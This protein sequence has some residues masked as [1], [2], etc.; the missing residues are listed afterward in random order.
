M[1]NSAEHEIRN[2]HKYRISRNSVFSGSDMPRML[3]FLLINVKMPTNVGILVF[4]SRKNF[5]LILI[6]HGKSFITL[7]PGSTLK[8]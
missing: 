4:T 3:F 8:L 2:S 5:M 1:L 6:E 7:G